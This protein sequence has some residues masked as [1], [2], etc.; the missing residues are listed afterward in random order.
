MRNTLTK[1]G[2]LVLGGVLLFSAAP[3]Q[4]T[5]ADDPYSVMD[6]VIK[7][8]KKVKAGGKIHYE[9]S[10]VNT[11]PHV[12]DY[13]FLGG[14]L[15]KGIVDRLYW[16]GPKG[17][18]CEWDDSGFWCWGDWVLKKGHEDWLEIDVRLKKST[19]GTAV[20]Q[21]G[22]LVYDIPTGMENLSKEEVDRLGGFDVWFY[23]KKV[24]TKIVR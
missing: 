14:K 13:Y 12:A 3:A 16:D 22:A 7:A 5:T 18:K 11:G 6:V 15:P 1:I 24:K 8:P 20:A 4:A 9:I 21:L 23:G 19:K 2:A 17:T 10:A